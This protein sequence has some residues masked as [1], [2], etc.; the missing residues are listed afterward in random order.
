V[1]VLA[2]VGA[3]C[4]GV[5][6]LFNPSLFGF[7]PRC[8]FYQ[9]T[10]LLCPGCG[11]LRAMHQ[12]LH[13]H[14]TEAIRF[15]GL[16]IFSLPFAAMTGGFYFIRKLQGDPFCLVVKP[17]WLWIGGVALLLFSILRNLPFARAHG[18]TP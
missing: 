1:V 16:L 11:A 4:L 10:G 14:L 18:W 6:Y 9:T 15:N 8:A 3:T 17:V 7:Y 13:G 2:A 12:L 5:L